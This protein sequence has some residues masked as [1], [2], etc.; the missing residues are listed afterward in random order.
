MIKDTRIS[1]R[2]KPEE[3][4]EFIQTA[5]ECGCNPDT[6]GFWKDTIIE[7]MARTKDYNQDLKE[8]VGALTTSKRRAL[9]KMIDSSAVTENLYEYRRKK[10]D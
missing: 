7:F 10:H 4:A 5:K 1:L 6:H 9:K 3:D 8:K 2:L